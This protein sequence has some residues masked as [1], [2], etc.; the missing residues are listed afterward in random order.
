MIAVI[1]RNSFDQERG[2][3]E[4]S[5]TFITRKVDRG[6]SS[7]LSLTQRGGLLNAAAGAVPLSLS[8]NVP[9]LVTIA[10]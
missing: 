7:P 9:N 4:T 5:L 3:R 2:L 10:S 6:R 1:N 8:F